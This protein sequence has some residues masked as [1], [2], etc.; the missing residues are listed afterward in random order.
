MMPFV[1]LEF[2]GELFPAPKDYE[3]YLELNFGDYLVLPKDM[4][5]MHDA[6]PR[7]RMASVGAAL[8]RLKDLAAGEKMNDC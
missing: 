4:G 2:E 3:W 5:R 1:P 8:A 7:D 6:F